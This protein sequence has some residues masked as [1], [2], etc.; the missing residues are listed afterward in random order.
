MD[1]QSSWILEGGPEKVFQLTE[2]HV[3]LLVLSYTAEREYFTLGGC[4][5]P[6]RPLHTYEQRENE[7]LDTVFKANMSR[8]QAFISIHP[9]NCAKSSF[10]MLH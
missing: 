6:G 8:E 5:G 10:L 4:A 2:C 9:W 7:L 1:L 3:S